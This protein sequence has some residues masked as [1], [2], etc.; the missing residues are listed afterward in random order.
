[1]CLFV[2]FL[3]LQNMYIK[4][5]PAPGSGGGSIKR[6]RVSGGYTGASSG[7]QRPLQP[8]LLYGTLASYQQR[9]Q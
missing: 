3:L 4:D 9:Y 6:A 2:A 7:G 5:E 8:C 1:M